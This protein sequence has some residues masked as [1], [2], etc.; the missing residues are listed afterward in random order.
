MLRVNI[1]AGVSPEGKI[2]HSSR[3]VVSEEKLERKERVGWGGRSNKWNKR[4]TVDNLSTHS[5]SAER[6]GIDAG[7]GG[8]GRERKGKNLA[9]F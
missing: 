7:A 4:R 6:D 5:T 8:A 9:L 2:N 1:C 3:C